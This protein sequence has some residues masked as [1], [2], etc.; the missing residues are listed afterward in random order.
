MKKKVAVFI[1]IVI[2]FTLCGCK[3][4]NIGEQISDSLNP[5]DTVTADTDSTDTEPVTS[6][7][8]EITP[9]NANQCVNFAVQDG[10]IYFSNKYDNGSLYS[11]NT[12][13]S[14]LLKL[15]DD[16]TSQFCV[17]DGKI[18]YRNDTE[19]SKLYSITTD[20]TDRHK[21][22]DDT[23]GSAFWNLYGGRI[24][25]NNGDDAGRLYS[26]KVDGSDRKKLSDESP[27]YM[28]VLGD[29]IYY[30][31][32]EGT[33]G[34][35][36]MKTDGSERTKISDD[37]PYTITAAGDWI[38]YPNTGDEYKLYTMKADGSDRHKVS[39]DY[40]RNVRILG[41]RIY[42]QNGLRLFSMKADGSDK[43][44]L[45]DDQVESFSVWNGKI[46][47]TITGTKIYSM[48]TDGGSKQVLADLSVG[49]YCNVTYEVSGRLHEDMPEYRFEAMGMKRGTE[50]Y[51][52]SYVMGL[53][54]YEDKGN[55]ILTADFSETN[56]DET[57]GYPVFNEM[58]DTMGLHITD[59]NFDG[60]K[61]VIILNAFCGAH[62]NTWYDCWL[63]DPQTSSFKTCKSF[64]Q[65]CNPSIDPENKC[66]YSTGGSG[67]SFWG[68]SIYKF[69]DGEFVL[70]N[71]L[72][73][74]WTGVKETALVDG[75]MTVIREVKYPEDDEE[76][77][78][79][80]EAAEMKY[81]QESELWQLNN[82]RWYWYGGHHADEWLE[83]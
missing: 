12:D 25:Y 57:V 78:A 82:P 53:K 69:I 28:Y 70:T 68:G 80:M 75:K 62:A 44:A 72:Y 31:V 17:S 8:L 6:D 52:I 64:S 48:N 83:K 51:E 47:Y 1:A 54:V 79:E 45:S 58:M 37:M 5:A 4:K 73:T 77:A 33:E 60:Y 2:A 66:I 3:L 9:E 24:Y 55:V 14:D 39:D 43:K 26:I 30:T 35:Y 38:Y 61:D 50:D 40:A 49:A 63:W 42:Y 15:N 74:D 11:M 7:T 21:L 18:Y 23:I 81:Y 20:G 22:S 41:D 13:G 19:G 46:Y 59:V 10:K 16:N 56:G 71:D 34:I 67:A 32:L 65:I 29:R 27:L 36:S 76:K